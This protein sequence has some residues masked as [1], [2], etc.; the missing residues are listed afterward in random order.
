MF[1]A[2]ELVKQEANRKQDHLLPAVQ[3]VGLYGVISRLES[4]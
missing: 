4:N 3:T 2:E 1:Q